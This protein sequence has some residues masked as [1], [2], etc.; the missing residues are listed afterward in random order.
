[1]LAPTLTLSWLV[2]SP[3]S[4]TLNVYSEAMEGLRYPAHRTA[5]LEPVMLPGARMLEAS[6]YSDVESVSTQPFH[7]TGS[8]N[9]SGSDG[10]GP[11]PS[12]ALKADER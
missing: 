1:M 8:S 11:A 2:L 9:P 6:V 10:F 5:K 3:L 4:S 7:M 12:L